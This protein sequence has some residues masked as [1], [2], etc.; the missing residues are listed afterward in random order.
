MKSQFQSWED[1]MSM[2]EV[3]CLIQLQH[4]N[5]V[6]LKE[7]I[8]SSYTNE[9]YL[10]FELLQSDLHELI[11]KKRKSSDR[12]TE[13]EVKAPECV[14]KSRSYNYKV[15]IFAVGCIM[16]ELFTLQPLF[17]GEDA[18]DQFKVLIKIL[19]TPKDSKWSDFSRLF[20]RI[21]N[22]MQDLPN[23]KKK[24]LQEIITEASPEAVEIIER[25]LTYNPND[26]PSAEE[27]MLDPY[28]EEIHNQYLGIDKKSK[29]SQALHKKPRT[30]QNTFESMKITENGIRIMTMQ[31][32]N[33]REREGSTSNEDKM[34]YDQGQ[35][36][37]Q[38]I[39]NQQKSQPY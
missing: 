11:K 39:L 37:K 2:N 30:N 27:L 25:M 19:G 6:K 34:Y 26:R 9:L 33:E 7:V 12:F 13:D 22:K 8:R 18:I 10:I 16:A 29:I 24:D 14:L 38:M 20:K 1:A 36:E 5:I 35:D 21:S 31:E 3:K 28:F 23:Y 32:G 15:D 4:L 17:P